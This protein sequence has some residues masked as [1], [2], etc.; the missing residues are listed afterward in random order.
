MSPPEPPIIRLEPGPPLLLTISSVFPRIIDDI[1]LIGTDASGGA[2]FVTY[3]T[4]DLPET[5]PYLEVRI[6]TAL[7][8]Q[9]SQIFTLENVSGLMGC[10]FQTWMLRS[11]ET[12]CCNNFHLLLLQLHT[13]WVYRVVDAFCKRLYL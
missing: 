12:V 8:I 4:S 2:I 9:L 7:A 13:G 10:K 11:M 5:E 6:S 1:H 3:V